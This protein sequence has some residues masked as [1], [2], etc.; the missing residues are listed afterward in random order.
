[1][2]YDSRLSCPLCRVEDSEGGNVSLLPQVLFFGPKS[3]Q[4][5]LYDYSGVSKWRNIIAQFTNFDLSITSA[6]LVIP[7][8][9]TVYV[10]VSSGRYFQVYHCPVG[11]CEA[12]NV[13]QFRLRQIAIFFITKEARQTHCYDLS[14]I[15]VWRFRTAHAADVD[16]IMMQTS[17]VVLECSSFVRA[18]IVARDFPARYL[19]TGWARPRAKT[20]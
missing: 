20:N 19:Y 1:M 7:E 13:M 15:S 5:L 10:W 8:C 6:L 9:T 3:T 2:N 17:V 12:Q 14:G 4:R 11:N 18:S 16:P